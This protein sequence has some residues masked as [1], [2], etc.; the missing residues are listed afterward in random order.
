MVVIDT[1][2]I[3]EHLRTSSST[4]TLME[5][6]SKY[7]KSNLAISVITI[8]ELYEGK[9]SKNKQKEQFLL[10]TISPLKILSYTY[11]IAKFAGQIARDL[12]RSIELANCAIASTCIL[13]NAKLATLNKKDFVGIKGLKL[14]SL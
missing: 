9:S 7:D 5:I 6:A 1:S 2:I 4:S 14:E 12:P 3:I 8:Q 13:N 11:D 10:A